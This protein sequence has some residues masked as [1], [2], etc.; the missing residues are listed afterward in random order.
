MMAKT[1]CGK[2][3]QLS[4]KI[5]EAIDEHPPLK[6]RVENVL[7]KADKLKGVLKTMS[8]KKIRDFVMKG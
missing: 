8:F 6:K 1:D 7:K 4:N 5:G 3:C 2:I